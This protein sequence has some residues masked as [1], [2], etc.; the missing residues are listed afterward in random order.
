[1]SGSPPT[2]LGKYQIIREIARSND[3]VYE[4]YDSL[5][6]RRVALKELAMPGGSTPQ[7]K[8][9]RVKR[10]LREARA[11]GSLAHP[12]IMTVYEVG[13]E[14][15]RYFIAMEYLDGKTL[16]N[17]LDTKGFLP[18]ERATEIA[19]AVL[20][21]LEYAHTKGVIHRDIKPDNIQLI[22]SGG[23]KLTDFGIARLTFEPN[24]T[25][26]GQVFGTPSYMSP[27]QVVGRDIDAR[28]DLFSVGVVLYEMLSGRKPF[29]GDSVVT[30][31]YSIMNR[32]P[33]RPQQM[34]W[35]LWQVVERA[36]DKSPQL[37][38][39]SA[40]EFIDAIDE[41]MRASSSVVL[42]PRATSGPPPQMSQS[43]HGQYGQA[44]QQ[45]QSPYN[46]PVQPTYTG[47]QQQQP[48]AQMP[49]AQQVPYTPGAGQPYHQQTIPPAYGHP[50]PVYY[51]PPARKPFVLMSP[52]TKRTLAYVIIYTLVFVVIGGLIIK[53][54][55][56]SANYSE[57]Q[58]AA[59]QANTAPVAEAQD[60]AEGWISQGD[61]AR[62]NNDFDTAQGFYER[63]I[64]SSS[65]NPDGYSRLAE[66]FM[67][68]ASRSVD[69]SNVEDYLLHAADNYEQAAAAT[70]DSG[71]K[72]ALL[73]H[74]AEALY[75]LALLYVKEGN[76]RDARQVLYRARADAHSDFQ[77]TQLINGMLER[78][79]G[80][81]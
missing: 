1:M 37:R 59:R 60:P 47:Y 32:N 66:V 20:E 4:A 21:G 26:D 81:E 74:A 9:D 65:N 13:Q 25:M 5:M 40:R 69:Q 61:T 79:S 67:E 14:A 45:Y 28:S 6:N 68:K 34:N 7:Q 56:F 49:P 33:D 35:A 57:R 22:S 16:R 51:P 8:E 10:F 54:I 17:E 41:A 18:A 80:S 15:D 31:T 76:P 78:L 55:D 12:N 42:D 29:P 48:Y 11:A 23:I 64:K 38:P 58:Q 43:P 19:K 36:L 71:E 52:Q 39:R 27:E 44:P 3:I 73:V 2:S 72:D 62:K 77:E 24:L 30:I 46:V 75:Q 63:A 70:K 53:I 50:V